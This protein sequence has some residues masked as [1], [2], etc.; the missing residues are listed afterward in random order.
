MKIIDKLTKE[1]EARMLEWRHKW[2]KIGL[3]T[4]ETDWET[5]EENIRLA[6]KKAKIPF[7]NK[8]IIHVQSPLV[9]AFASSIAD[10]ILQG[11]EQ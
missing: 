3:Q 5:G 4:G 6:Y 9:G 8:P 11:R 10:R 7:P 1:Q 2:I